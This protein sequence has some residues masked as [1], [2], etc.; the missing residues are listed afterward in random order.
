MEVLVTM[1]DDG[2]NKT[3]ALA[4]CNSVAVENIM[5]TLVIA[6]PGEESPIS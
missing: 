5:K 3:G 6:V 4:L 2:D 1:G